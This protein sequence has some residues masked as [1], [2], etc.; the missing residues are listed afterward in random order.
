MKEKIKKH[1]GK[2][3]ILAGVFTFTLGVLNFN[4]NRDCPVGLLPSFN[5]GDCS[6]SVKYFYSD[7][8]RFITGLGATLAVL[9]ILMIRRADK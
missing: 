8:T 4:G 2:I 7:E 6:N 3:L 5:K 1:L 9:G